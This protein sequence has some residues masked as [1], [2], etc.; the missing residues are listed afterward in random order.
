M[1]IRHKS[2][3]M[4][5]LSTHTKMSSSWARQY[6]ILFILQYIILLYDASVNAFVI[7]C[8]NQQ[9]D[10]LILYITQD[11][12]SMVSLTILLGSFFST[13]IFRVGLIHLLYSRFRL[14][15][16]LCVTYIV[17][18]IAL[19]SW[20][21]TYQWTSPQIHHWNKGFHIT[22]AIHRIVAVIYYY[23]YKRATLRISDPRLY[24]T[25]SWEQNQL[26]LP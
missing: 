16:M 2:F 1:E 25:S 11:L 6:T 13:Y 20:H 8:P 24:E 15:I 17:L 12:C 21:M 4:D 22:Y 10:M 26:S 5:Q 7:L 18:S 23:F 14:A 3:S 9:V 19:H